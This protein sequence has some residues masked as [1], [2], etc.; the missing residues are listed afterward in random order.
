MPRTC[1]ALPLPPD[2]RVGLYVKQD[3]AP[4]VPDQGQTN[5]EQAIEGSQH[6]SLTFSLEGC[7]LKAES[8]IL[9]RNGSVTVQQE[10]NESKNRQKE[11]WHVSRL[12]VFILFQVNLLQADG[13]MAKNREHFRSAMNLLA[14]LVRVGSAFEPQPWRTTAGPR[15]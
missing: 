8:G 14:P 7:E 3:S 2:D 4:A 13:I 9:Y 5:P 15:L 12:F 10:S 6:W 1:E 11:T